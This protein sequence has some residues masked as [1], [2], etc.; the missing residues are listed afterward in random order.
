[1]SP[2]HLKVLKPSQSENNSPTHT[3]LL[4]DRKKSLPNYCKPKNAPRMGGQ[5]P[6][7]NGVFFSRRSSAHGGP[8][9][10]SS[11]SGSTPDV[12]SG[13][14]SG[15]DSERIEPATDRSSED[16]GGERG[17]DGVRGVGDGTF[18]ALST[19]RAQVIGPKK[20]IK[21]RPTSSKTRERID[22]YEVP[23]HKGR[24]DPFQLFHSAR[25]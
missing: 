8:G 24:N 7:V 20:L 9:L 23:P 3:W 16:Y 10:E 25:K 13:Y 1:M 6:G 18:S 14:T 19:F 4:T 12:W 2:L 17:R 5:N 15:E 21:S 22:M 11:G